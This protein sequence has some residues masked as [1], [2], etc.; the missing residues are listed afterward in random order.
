[1]SG[2][3]I[4]L[5]C[6]FLFGLFLAC[7]AL[8]VQRQIAEDALADYSYK[9]NNSMVE[10]RLSKKKYIRAYRRFYAPHKLIHMAAAFMSIAL[11][12]LPAAGLFRFILIKLWESSGRPDSFQPGFL[13]FNIL[14]MLMLIGFWTIIFFLTAQRYY[15]T[16]PISLRDEMIRAENE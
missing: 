13:V 6:V 14:I 8:L 1:M 2:L 5:G 11:L 12:S 3:S 4:F 9:Q 15:K 7:R 10:P 16:A